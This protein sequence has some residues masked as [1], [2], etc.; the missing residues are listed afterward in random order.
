MYSTA[1]THGMFDLYA[2][3]LQKNWHLQIWDKNY[4]NIFIKHTDLIFTNIRWDLVTR[5]HRGLIFQG[6]KALNLSR[7]NGSMIQRTNDP[8][9]VARTKQ[10]RDTTNFASPSQEGCQSEDELSLDCQDGGVH[11][12]H[13]NIN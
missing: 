9:D 6:K 8:W 12:F 11:I 7:F 2:N 13:W 1:Q 4:R 5:I 10:G 3:R